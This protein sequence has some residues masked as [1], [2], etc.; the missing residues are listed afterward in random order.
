MGTSMF[1]V[2]GAPVARSSALTSARDLVAEG[3]T[4][5]GLCA[6][7]NWIIKGTVSSHIFLFITDTSEKELSS[8]Q[9]K[10]RC[11][12]LFLKFILAATRQIASHVCHFAWLQHLG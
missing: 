7:A 1:F 4:V 2:P 9:A 12:D 5:E 3:S 11:S 10:Y 6:N 8:G